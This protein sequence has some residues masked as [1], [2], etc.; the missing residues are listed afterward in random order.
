MRKL[1]TIIIC[2]FFLASC[3]EDTKADHSSWHV[4]IK[5]DIVIITD[6][7]VAPLSFDMYVDSFAE[8]AI[9]E[10]SKLQFENKKDL[11]FRSIL[12][13]NAEEMTTVALIFYSKDN[14]FYPN[15]HTSIKGFYS[16]PD[17]VWAHN[18]L[19]NDKL[20]SLSGAYNEK[21]PELFFDLIGKQVDDIAEEEMPSVSVESNEDNYT[22]R[23][24]DLLNDVRSGMEKSE[25]P[26]FAE[27]HYDKDEKAIV[28]RV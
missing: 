14:S 5:D 11:I 22:E 28:F 24:D 23:L 4:L 9:K 19:Q 10:F 26:D 8:E 18:D 17:A 27:L 13:N 21:V 6:Y 16:Y 3:D 1:L 2:I 7:N 25:H 15:E 12:P 20:R